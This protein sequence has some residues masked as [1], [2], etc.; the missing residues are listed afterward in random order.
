M[1]SFAYILSLV[2]LTQVAAADQDS[3]RCEAVFPYA[4]A[5]R[6]EPV[7]DQA[8]QILPVQTG[9][10]KREVIAEGTRVPSDEDLNVTYKSGA[11]SIFIGVSSPGT[12]EYLKEAV[13]VSRED[14]ISDATIDRRGEV[15]CLESPPY[16]YKVP[17]F[18]AW[19]NGSYFFYA[20]ASTPAVLD[21]LLNAFPY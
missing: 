3:S 18:I 4:L 1:A 12:L 14:T 17:D 16:F 7:S 15:V 5:A 13:E 6:L 21:E 2:T 9:R 8:T 20:D 10:F 19:T 11:D